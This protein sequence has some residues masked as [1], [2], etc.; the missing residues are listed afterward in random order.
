MRDPDRSSQDRRRL[1][2]ETMRG[3]A[4]P[5][6][7][8]ARRLRRAEPGSED[9]RPAVRWATRAQARPAQGPLDRE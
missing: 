7:V 2:I 3:H 5:G 8:I 6:R 9:D 1:L 4:L